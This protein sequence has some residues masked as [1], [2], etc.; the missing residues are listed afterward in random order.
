MSVE[1]SLS[2]IRTAILIVRLIE[3]N[4]LLYQLSHPQYAILRVLHEA[5]DTGMHSGDLGNRLVQI[6]PDV[7]R[8]LDR[9]EKRGFVERH[10]IYT[11]RRVIIV[12]ITAAAANIIT[13]LEAPMA[14]MH[15]SLFQDMPSEDAQK[16]IDGLTKIRERILKNPNF[17]P[18]I[19]L[20]TAA[21]PIVPGSNSLPA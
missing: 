9:L 8:L 17:S 6:T 2:I 7:T 1:A 19:T 18:A 3:K 15:T 4:L 16:L 10:R 14:Q 13:E 20:N 5:G 12:K 21:S 11:D